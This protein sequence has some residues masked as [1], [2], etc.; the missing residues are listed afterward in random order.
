MDITPFTIPYQSGVAEIRPCCKEDN[1]VDYAVWTE[2]KLA[3]TITR[4]PDD[5]DRWVIA[6]KNADDNFSDELVQETGKKI[7]ER[8]GH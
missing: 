2:N 5:E 1:V 4:D 3:F 7:A 8:Y 6:M